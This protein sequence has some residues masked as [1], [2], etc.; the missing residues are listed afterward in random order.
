MKSI[1]A[2]SGKIVAFSLIFILEKQNIHHKY[3]VDLSCMAAN[4]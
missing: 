4:T 1:S 3:L 2:V